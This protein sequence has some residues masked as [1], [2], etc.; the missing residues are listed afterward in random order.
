MKKGRIAFAAAAIALFFFALLGGTA[1]YIARTGAYVE[2]AG[3]T[4]ST[5]ASEALGVPVAVGA[6]RVE[7][8]HTIVLDGVTVQDKAGEE[9][10]R[11]ASAEVEMS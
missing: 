10:L 6:V 3:R 5:K 7:S 8:W 9:I 2:E 11:A 4:L 1:A